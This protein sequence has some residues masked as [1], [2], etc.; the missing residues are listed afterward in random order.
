VSGPLGPVPI[1]PNKVRSGVA[2][3]TERRV[4][5]DWKWPFWSVLVLSI[6]SFTALLM[7]LSASVWPDI[8]ASSEAIGLYFY[9]PLTL[10]PAILIAAATQT[11]MRHYRRRNTW[12][13]LSFAVF[14]A[15]V[16]MMLSGVVVGE[17]AAF[18]Q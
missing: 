18:K 6:P 4:R 15:L 2:V 17:M 3:V 11:S 13:V 14:A 12:L 16:A 9:T 10:V 5:R 8:L 1:R 7:M